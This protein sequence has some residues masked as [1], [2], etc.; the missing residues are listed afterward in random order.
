M[1]AFDYD[2]LWAKSRVFVDRA[3]RA[4]NAEDDFAYYMWS[5]ISLEILGKS[6]LAAIHPALVADPSHAHSLFAACGRQQKA[7]VKSIMAKTVFERLQSL[8]QEFDS[9]AKDECLKMADRRNAELH[10]GDS[11]VTGLDPQIWVPGFWRAAVVILEEQRRSLEDW[12]GPEESERIRKI[13]ENRAEVLRQAVHARIASRKADYD[14][15][16]PPGSPERQ[17]AANRALV[18]SFPARHSE[19]WDEWE[20][21]DCPAC[22][23]K[24]WLLGLGWQERVVEEVREQIDEFDFNIYDIVDIAYDVEGFACEECGLRLRSRDEVVT[25][26]LPEVFTRTDTRE[27]E[28]EPDYGNE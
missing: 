10:S 17:G 8:V 5:A 25:A 9:K 2:A 1:T 18:R 21:H 19:N 28:Y 11:P 22:D 24:A 7:T 27:P 14:S 3:L 12:V 4:R 6:T 23:S 26:G 20:E 16:F 13:L 15:R